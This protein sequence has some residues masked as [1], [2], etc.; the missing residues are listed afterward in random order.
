MF[1]LAETL[2]AAV[3]QVTPK[4]MDGIQTSTPPPS[5]K[6]RT[7]DFTHTHPTPKLPT[8]SLAPFF[9][10]QIFR[11]ALPCPSRELFSLGRQ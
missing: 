4:W 11:Q 5:E 6:D 7:K 2:E 9:S 8:V 3:K 1:S 10:F